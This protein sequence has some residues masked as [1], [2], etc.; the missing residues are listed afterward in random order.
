MTVPK[1]NNPLGLPE[2]IAD[3]GEFASSFQH[4]LALIAADP[5]VRESVGKA[6]VG[7]P[8]TVEIVPSAEKWAKKQID[9]A[10]AAGEDWVQGMQNPSADPKAAALAAKGKWKENVTKA[11]ANDAFAKGIAKY[12][13]DEAIETAIKIGAAGFANGITARTGKIQRVIADLQP[14]VAALKR[15]ISAMPQDTEAQREARLLAAKRG[16]QEIGKARQG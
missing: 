9:R 4:S 2:S 10:V 14:K 8:I 3:L 1:M 13:V 11:V 16:M 6:Q 7:N 5:A 12:S 15:T